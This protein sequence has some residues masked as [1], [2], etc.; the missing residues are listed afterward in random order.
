[1][2]IGDARLMPSKECRTSSNTDS[3]KLDVAPAASVVGGLLPLAWVWGVDI[4][5]YGESALR[6]NLGGSYF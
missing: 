5:P 3:P 1:M 2:A 4:E 6:L